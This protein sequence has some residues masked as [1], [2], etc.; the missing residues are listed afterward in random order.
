MEVASQLILIGAALFLLSILAGLMSS[1]IGAPLL[2]V[3]LVLG[4]LAG[5]DGPGG[6]QFDDF[7]AAFLIG[8]V[9]LAI[10]LFD[11]GLRTRYAAFRLVLW[12]AV[13]LA[14]VGVVVTA[15]I[16]AL[17]AALLLDLNWIEA[18][19]VGSV[20]A[21]TDA[22]AVFFLLNQHGLTLQQRVSST[23]E[24]ESGINDPMAIFLTLACVQLL[25]AGETSLSWGV[26]GDFILQ[27]GG[28]AIVGV[29]GG[30]VLLW[31]IN[32]VV[33]A[34]GLYPIFAAAFALCLFAGAQ[35]LHT[36]GFVAIYLAGL[37]LGNHRH[38]A[39]QVIER[40]H[41][42]LAWLSQIAMFLILGLLVTPSRLLPSLLP[43]LAI[44]LVLMVV[45]RPAA[46]WLCLA[47]FRFDWRETSFISWVG[48]RGAVPIF[49][50]TAPVLAGVPGARIYFDLAFVTVL[51]SLVCQGWTVSRVARA[52]SLDVPRT[53]DRPERLEI[54]LPQSL[55]RGVA[56]YVVGE[57]S[58][59]LA[60]AFDNLPLPRRT[61][62]LSVI[63]DGT[64]LDRRTLD[65][66]QPGDYALTFAP[67]EQV[68]MLDRLF[69]AR[70]ADAG[71]DERRS[72][73]G[74]FSFDGTMLA[75][76]IAELYGL[77]ISPEERSLPV[78]EL[79][80]RRLGR[81]PVVGDRV[82]LGDVELIIRELDGERIAEVGV[83][84]DPVERDRRGVADLVAIIRRPR[85]AV[86]RLLRRVRRR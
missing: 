33:I 47:P 37:I 12:P 56:G 70:P 22:A 13:S 73:F 11:G 81:H 40:F 72:V 6:I 76:A 54:D 51:V 80:R 28:G 79:I 78:G 86:V 46:V 66:L 62:V 49:L 82:R 67:A 84:L 8:S 41:N 63:R 45:A 36:S 64:V 17:V 19:L 35:V 83:E 43:A 38:R 3:F 50:A 52:L 48:L 74:E 39:S 42:G 15:A 32:R 60:H 31:L 20:V 24:I 9:S 69:A 29:G 30:H 85:D 77:A 71:Q 55:D 4:M 44:A 65:R 26:L 34:A 75:G 18:L 27:M 23:L 59:A 61:R 25:L 68:P 21:S 7:R 14:T 2:L 58:A 57:R 5:E 1:R 16:T 53:E 10:I